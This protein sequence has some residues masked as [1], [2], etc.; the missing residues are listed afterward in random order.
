MTEKEFLKGIINFIELPAI[1]ELIQESQK[2]GDLLNEI[3]KFQGPSTTELLLENQEKFGELLRVETKYMIV[4]YKDVNILAV[5]SGFSKEILN[6]L[7]HDYAH[8]AAVTL[9]RQF[10]AMIRNKKRELVEKRS[11]L[12]RRDEMWGITNQVDIIKNNILVLN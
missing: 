2:F 4:L 6:N 8:Q 3:M 11:L 5:Q 7:H 12:Y 10:F 1:I 9:G